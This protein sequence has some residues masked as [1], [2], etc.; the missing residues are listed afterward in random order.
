LKWS[1][2]TPITAEDYAWTYKQILDPANKYPYLD[3]L[4]DVLESVTAPDAKTVVGKMK[5]ANIYAISQMSNQPLPKSAWEGKAWSDPAANTNIDAPTVVS[6]PWKLKEWKRGQYITYERNDASTIW[7]VPLLDSV[8]I[9]IVPTRAVQVQKLKA[10]ELDYVDLTAAEYE[11]A[12][13]ATNASVVEYYA[14]NASWTYI[15]FNF[16]KE[17]LK[18]VELRKALAYATPQKDIVDKLNLGLG[19][20]IYSPVPQSSA[21]YNPQT[22]KYDY[23]LEKA[24]S[25]LTAAGYKIEGGKLKDKAGKEIPKLKIYY[26][27][28]NKIREGIATVTQQTYKELGI[29]LEIVPLEFQAYVDYISKEPFDY[30]LFILG[31]RST[32][33]PET[34]DQVWKGIPSLNSGAWDTDVKKQVVDLYDKANKEFDISKRKEIMGQIQVQTATD[35]PYVFVFQVKNLVAVSNKFTISPATNFGINYNQYTDWSLK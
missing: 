20:P 26:N 24:K 12:K 16:R 1:N 2:G 21:L 14:P 35:L 11:E 33:T 15:G 9:Q 31:W 4:S 25:T 22:P 29:E 32:T 10:G 3:D 19:Q 17:Y 6:G 30:D 13:K 18:D 34:F 8:T 5:K 23:S 27:S 28:D 7:P